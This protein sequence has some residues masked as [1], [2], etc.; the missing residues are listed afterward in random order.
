M[1]RMAQEG[2]IGSLVLKNRIVRSATMDAMA[3]P[4]GSVTDRQ[5][6]FYR[7]LAEGGSALIITGHTWVQKNGQASAN[8]MGIDDDRFISGLARIARVVHDCGSGA[9][10][11]LQLTHCGRQTAE[12]PDPI[13]PSAVFEPYLKRMPREMS[14]DEIK[15]TIVAFAEGARRARDAGFDGVQLHAAHGW[16]LSGFLSPFTNRRTDSYGGTT[17]SRCRILEEIYDSIRARVGKDFPVMVK[18]NVD[19][20]IIGGVDLAEAKR[21]AKRLVK[22]GFAGIETS[23]GM[24]ECLVRSEAELGWK[25]VLIP[26]SRTNVKAGENE[27]Y[28]RV[29][30]GEIKKATKSPIVL[31]GGLR[32]VGVI[33]TILAQ[34]DADFI[35]LSRPLIREPDLPR[36]WLEGI[37]TSA[38]CISCNSCL[39]T[40]WEGGL[41]CLKIKE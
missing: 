12:Q 19:D 39:G 36:K 37:K 41:R 2:K 14:I 25:P 20:F 26:E 5:I 11:V 10:A 23:G 21:I 18:M 17:E 31:V 38:D 28:F 40:L 35:S 7:Q 13:A 4:D 29:S 33:E 30:A 16:L 32:S 15:K 22:K 8:Q 3:T 27:G 34:G 24:W 6:V 9:K 1:L